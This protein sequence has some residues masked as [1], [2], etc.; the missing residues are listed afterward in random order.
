MSPREVGTLDQASHALS[1]PEEK[2]VA[3]VAF[4]YIFCFHAALRGAFP[5][6]P[7]GTG[8]C[9]K[10]GRAAGLSGAITKDNLAETQKPE[11]D[12]HN[13]D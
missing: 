3:Q 5:V 11:K 10:V 8:Q 12:K 13:H 9:R 6:D 4:C 2:V 7:T 1:C